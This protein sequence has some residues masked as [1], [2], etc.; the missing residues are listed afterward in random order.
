MRNDK[1]GVI[2]ANLGT[3]DSPQPADVRRYLAEFLW[4]PR[5]IKVWRPLWWL[6]LNLV[7]LNTRPK[8]SAEAYQSIWTDQGS[9]WLTVSR[10][11][12]DARQQE[13]A[14]LPLALGMR[15]GNP[16]MESAM[17]ELRD[18]GVKH[19]IVLPLYP[20]F[21]DTTITSVED[22]V[23]RVARALGDEFSY[24]MIN[25]YHNNPQYIAALAD[26]IRHYQ[27]Q[28]GKPE[29]L[30]MS[31]HGIPQEY[32]DDGDP[33]RGQCEETA[34]LL[35][36]ALELDDSMWKLTFQSR[37][38]PKQWLQPYTDKTLEKLPSA[39]IKSVQVVYPGFSVDCLETLE[40]I[41]IENCEVF[42]E[43]GGEKYGYIPCLNDSPEH[44]KLMTTLIEREL[45]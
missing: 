42:M 9:P 14:D 16:S 22:E 38:G 37:L 31:F 21:S 30:V 3:P 5:V 19:F 29:L 23:V 36:N 43:A 10:Q 33:Y 35:A 18:T 44:I 40:E 26:S 39:G 45:K 13:L 4:D 25:G 17:N 32:V 2:L 12:A 24:S 27:S 41:A 1:V 6:I 34:R 11:Q 8:K 20:Q 28:H 15:Y 7:I